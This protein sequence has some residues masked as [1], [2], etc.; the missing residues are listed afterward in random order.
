MK[1]HSGIT[2]HDICFMRSIESAAGCTWMPVM[3]WRQEGQRKRRK[4]LWD[5]HLEGEAVTTLEQDRPRY[6]HFPHVQ[7]ILFHSFMKGFKE[8]KFNMTNKKGTVGKQ[9]M[10]F[11]LWVQLIMALQGAIVP[12]NHCQKKDYSWYLGKPHFKKQHLPYSH[13]PSHKP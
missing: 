8:R 12:Q 10:V 3:D 1:G 9:G 13:M 5:G 2:M 4:R 11:T 6:F 7:L